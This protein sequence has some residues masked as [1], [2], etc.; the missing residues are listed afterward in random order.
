M[1]YLIDCGDNDLNTNNAYKD[2]NEISNKRLSLVI[3]SNLRITID[4]NDCVY[5]DENEM[6]GEKGMVTGSIAY[7]MFYDIANKY[8]DKSLSMI[9]LRNF[10]FASEYEVDE[11]HST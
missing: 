9:D 7:K 8:K 5:I 3:N 11:M 10:S 6:V 1:L 2:I 4:P